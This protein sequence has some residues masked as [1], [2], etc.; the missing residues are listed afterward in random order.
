VGPE[1][2]KPAG[3][4]GGVASNAEEDAASVVTDSPLLVVDALPLPSYAT[5]V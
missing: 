5:S 1:E 4:V 2:A 3:A